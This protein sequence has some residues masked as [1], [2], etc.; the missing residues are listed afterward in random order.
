MSEIKI[1]KIS[2]M[3]CRSCEILIERKLKDIPGVKKVK[4]NYHKGFAKI[5]SDSIISDSQIQSVIEES[6]YQLGDDLPKPIISRNPADW[7][8]LILLIIIFIILYFILRKFGFFNLGSNISRSSSNF[9]AVVLIGVTA[10]FSTCMALVGGLILGISAKFSEKNPQ[11]TAIQKF[12]PH[13]FFNA[14]RIIFFFTLGGII[15]MIGKV[16]QLSPTLLGILTIGVGLVMLFLGL[17]LTEIFPKFSSY[18]LTLPTSIAKILKINNRPDKEYSHANS[19][20]LGALTFFLPCGFTQAMQLLAISSGKFLSGALIMGL[21]ALGTTPGLLGIGG[22][23]SI[24]KGNFAR[25]F[26]KFVG[27]LVASLAI[28]NISNGLNLSGFN[29]STIFASNNNKTNVNNSNVQIVN[30]VQIIKMDQLSDR[31]SPNRFTIKN[32]IPTKWIIQSKASNSC[33]SSIISSK[34]GIRQFLQPGENTIEFTP[35]ETGT[36]Q[37]SCAMGMYIGFFEV[38]T[39]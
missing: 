36:I 30:G 35:T 33:S 23:T 25:K 34:L 6:G 28:I 13:L 16:I 8:D 12:R 38:V 4:V 3:H 21:F 5:F 11:A 17:Q 9:F 19:F 18:K 15:A 22:L 10:G 2:G 24:M 37:F 39:N 7:R 14:G 26:F 27:V 31:Y 29:L 32:N 1:I 20:F